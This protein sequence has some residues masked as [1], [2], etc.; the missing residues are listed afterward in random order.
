VFTDLVADRAFR[1]APVGPGD[2]AAML[3]ELRMAPM[4]DGYR[5]APA[6][7]RER[8]ADLLIRVGSVVEDLGEVAELDLNPVIGRG[9]ELM[10]VD[11]RIRVAAVPPRPDP[12]VRRLPL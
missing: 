5:G 3:D 4:L 6:V 10:I 11:A 9:A 7:S 2:A 8:L 12:L 1:L